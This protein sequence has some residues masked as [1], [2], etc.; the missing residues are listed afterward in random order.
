MTAPVM[1]IAM[2]AP[3]RPPSR[4]GLGRELIRQPSGL[5]GVVIL[6]VFSVLAVVP[7]LLVGRCRPR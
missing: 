7:D 6:V 5:I 2:E 4:F 3:L 1:P